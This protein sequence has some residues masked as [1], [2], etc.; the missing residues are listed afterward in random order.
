M[1]QKGW[2][3]DKEGQSGSKSFHKGH[4]DIGSAMMTSED[5]GTE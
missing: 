5:H 4:L 3:R 2:L 1:N